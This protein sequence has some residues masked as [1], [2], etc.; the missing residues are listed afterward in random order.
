MYDKTDRT[1]SMEMNRPTDNPLNRLLQ[2]RVSD[3]FLKAIDEFRSSQRPIPSRSE[4]VRQ[5]A[6]LGLGKTKA[7]PKTK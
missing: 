2:L 7:K 6:T 1:G 4:A 3:D 5:L